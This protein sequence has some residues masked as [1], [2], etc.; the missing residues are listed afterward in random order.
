MI[1]WRAGQGFTGGVLIPTAMT[2][3]RIAPAGQQAGRS[4]WR[5]SAWS[6]TFAPAI[7][8]T[9]GGWLTENCGWHYIFYL[10][11]VPGIAR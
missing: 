1:L 10:N 9:I 8:P 2:I 3:V 11:L 7:G 6:A 5:C 4:A